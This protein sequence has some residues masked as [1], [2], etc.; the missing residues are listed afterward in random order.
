VFTLIYPQ[1]E[2]HRFPPLLLPSPERN[3]LAG[4]FG[5]RLIVAGFEGQSCKSKI[6]ALAL[7]RNRPRHTI[8][9][10]LRV[11]TRSQD[12]PAHLRLF[13]STNHLQQVPSHFYLISRMTVGMALLPA[14]VL[15]S[16]HANHTANGSSV[17]LSPSAGH[18]NSR[19]KFFCFL[20][21]ND[22]TV[23]LLAKMRHRGA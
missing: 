10:R 18:A 20:H 6:A 16:P 1:L 7:Q 15:C 2:C 17:Y 23:C 11:F 19:S 12:V 22:W 5:P 4:T 3:D 14:L 9:G 21:L 8:V 13:G